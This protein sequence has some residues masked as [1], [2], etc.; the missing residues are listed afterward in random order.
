MNDSWRIIEQAAREQV[1]RELEAEQFAPL[2]AR[3]SFIAWTTAGHMGTTGGFSA[4]HRIGGV[5]R[6]VG[7]TLCGEKVPAPKRRVYLGSMR[8]VE[9][10][11]RCRYCERA[12]TQSG[13]AA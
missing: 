9:S 6:G 4:V 10:L 1:S 8:L 3:G 11:G 5:V 12:H 13:V 2:P 7:F